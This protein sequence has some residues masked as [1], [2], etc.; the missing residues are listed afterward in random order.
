MAPNSSR[1]R[2][3]SL[4]SGQAISQLYSS[5]RCW[6]A[7]NFENYHFPNF[8]LEDPNFLL[9]GRLPGAIKSSPCQPGEGDSYVVQF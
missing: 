4:M 1:L 5:E 9:P 2:N 3:L 8:I 7:N 6:R